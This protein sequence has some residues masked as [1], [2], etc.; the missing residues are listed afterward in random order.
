MHQTAPHDHERRWFTLQDGQAVTL[1][2][3]P[4]TGLR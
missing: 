4:T 1:N 3:R 2:L